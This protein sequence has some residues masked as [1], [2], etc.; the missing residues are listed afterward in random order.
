MM[1]FPELARIPFEE[2]SNIDTELINHLVQS[3]PRYDPELTDSVRVQAGRE[4]IRKGSQLWPI[5]LNGS[6]KVLHIIVKA[7]TPL[8]IARSAYRLPPLP[9]RDNLI[10]YAGSAL[11]HIESLPIDAMFQPLKIYEV[12]TERHRIIME[13]I[14]GRD[15]TSG[16]LAAHRFKTQEAPGNLKTWCQHSGTLLRTIH[17]TMPAQPCCELP[18]HERLLHEVQAPSSL[19]NAVTAAFERLNPNAKTATLFGDFWT[20]N[21]LIRGNGKI[22][23]IDPIAANSGPVYIDI[24][25]F[26][27]QLRMLPAQ[28]Y[29]HGLWSHGDVIDA[30]EEAFLRGY[31]GN[32][33]TD[34]PD[35][36]FY[37]TLIVL[38]KWANNERITRQRPWMRALKTIQLHWRQPYY[39]KLM[40]HFL[41]A[42]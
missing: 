5:D 41:T 20:G 19:R 21:I 13:R 31:F 12:D 40:H 30:C 17:A 2:T 8:P 36:N 33:I 24:A 34:W 9:D 39:I 29:S 26:L 32:G 3:A 7:R 6:D 27:V 14:D 28:V 42:Q 4:I 11:K 18:D 35:I 10:G 1:Y 22:A 25:Y 23:F 16:V 38:C 37:R 15:L